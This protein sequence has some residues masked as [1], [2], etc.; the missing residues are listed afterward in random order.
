LTSF[1]E[2][3]Y[4]EFEALLHKCPEIFEYFLLLAQLVD[5]SG[6]TAK[7]V[8]K[9]FLLGTW[10]FLKLLDNFTHSVDEVYYECVICLYDDSFGLKD[11][12]Y[13]AYDLC[14]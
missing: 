6:C 10:C 5:I 4:N 8:V 11:H 7:P 1:K 9:E 13:V 12:K 3:K 2:A 14:M